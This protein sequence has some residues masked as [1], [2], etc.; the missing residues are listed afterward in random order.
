MVRV[1]ILIVDVFS[2]GYIPRLSFKFGSTYTDECDVSLSEHFAN[3]RRQD[4]REAETLRTVRS[5]PNVTS[6]RG[7]PEVKDHLNEYSASMS[8][9]TPRNGEIQ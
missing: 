9:K 1:H 4:D 6:L 2:T 3:L 8:S 5:M 7:D